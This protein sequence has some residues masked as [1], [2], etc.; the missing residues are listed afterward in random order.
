MSLEKMPALLQ[1]H[2]VYFQMAHDCSLEKFDRV[3]HES[4]SLFDTDDG[5]L[6]VVPIA[7]Y[8]E[9]IA[10]RVSPKSAGKPREDELVS[11]DFLSPHTAV[12]RVRLRIHDKVFI[13]HLSWADVDGRFM[14]VA[15][16]WHDV[17]PVNG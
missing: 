1:A 4:C 5:V 15:K 12:T 6:T 13:D 16:V 10:N 17:T 11:V 14:I 8:R 7:D 9:V 3:F 2:D